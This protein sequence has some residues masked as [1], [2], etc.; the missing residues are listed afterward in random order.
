M[1][2]ATSHTMLHHPSLGTITLRR[3]PRVPFK[4]LPVLDSTTMS[5]QLPSKLEWF[6][7]WMEWK[8]EHHAAN[9]TLQEERDVWNRLNTVRSIEC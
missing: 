2:T 5:D 4:D 3:A 6:N 8:K 7:R 1:M 9:A